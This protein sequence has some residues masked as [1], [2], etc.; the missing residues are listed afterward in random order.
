MNDSQRKYKK[1]DRGKFF[2]KK[3]NKRYYAKTAGKYP[4]RPFDIWEDKIILEHSLPDR[5]ISEMLERSMQSIQVRR[6]KLKK[7]MGEKQC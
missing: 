7:D 2:R 3:Y 1:S 4:R 6:S 5:K